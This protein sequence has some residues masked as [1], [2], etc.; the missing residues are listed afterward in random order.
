MSRLDKIQSIVD[1]IAISPNM[2]IGSR[3]EMPERRRF[4]VN[5]AI[6]EMS[7]EGVG[8]KNEPT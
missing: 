1:L 7:R 5:E 4:Q 2:Q 3:V 6:E 8:G